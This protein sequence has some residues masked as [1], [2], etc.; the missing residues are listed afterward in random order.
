MC[1]Q[2]ELGSTPRRTKRWSVSRY[3]GRQTSPK[4]Q[5]QAKTIAARKCGLAS[6][7]VVPTVSEVCVTLAALPLP[8]P[9]TV[10]AVTTSCSGGRY[11]STSS[12]AQHEKKST[13]RGSTSRPSSSSTRSRAER[14][15]SAAMWCACHLDQVEKRTIGAVTPSRSSSHMANS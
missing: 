3:S 9:P 13:S 1:H 8:P 10:T 7:T 4:R 5:P 14:E 12:A 11:W 2:S 6:A 15:R